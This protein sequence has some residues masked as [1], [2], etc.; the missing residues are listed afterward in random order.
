MPQLMAEDA[1]MGQAK[2]QEHLPEWQQQ[3][4]EEVACQNQQHKQR[5]KEPQK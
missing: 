1:Q 5:Q 3:I 4:K 2:L